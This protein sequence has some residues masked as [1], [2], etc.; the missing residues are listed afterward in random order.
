MGGLGG[1]F[2]HLDLAFLLWEWL[3][4]LCPC[5]RRAGRCGAWDPGGTWH[6]G[7]LRKLEQGSSDK[8]M[9]VRCPPKQSQASHGDGG[10][11][12]PICA[13]AC[14]WGLAHAALFSQIPGAVPLEEIGC[15][16]FQKPA[17]LTLPPKF[18]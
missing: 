3:A 11:G 18:Y 16:E 4:P 6:S 17:L 9:C 8:V 15:R 12:G 10:D 2:L 5:Y 13:W 14:P 1:G 7:L